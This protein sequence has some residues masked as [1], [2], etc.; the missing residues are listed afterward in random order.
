MEK[1]LYCV[2][3][4]FHYKCMHPNHSSDLF[5]RLLVLALAK[6]KIP[7]YVSWLSPFSQ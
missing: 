2:V 7:V 1:N 4:Y 5:Q 3:P 6:T